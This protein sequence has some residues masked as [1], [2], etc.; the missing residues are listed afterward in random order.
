MTEPTV[1]FVE[2]EHGSTFRQEHTRK[3]VDL[4][5]NR[6]QSRAY[7]AIAPRRTLCLPWGRGVG[8]SWFIRAI[9]FMLVAQWRGKLRMRGKY[10]PLRGVRVV[11]LMPTLKQFKDVHGALIERENT[12]DWAFLGGRLDK[13]TWRI[14]F[15]DGSWIQPFPAELAN[16]RR[17]RGLR[18]DVVLTDETDD[19][20][21]S[22]FEAVARP[23]FSE[24][25]SLKIRLC[26]GTPTRGRHGLL[27][28][29]HAAGLSAAPQDERY[30]TFHATYRD[31]PETVDAEE[32]EDARAHTVPATFA[33]E[34]ECDFDAAEGLVYPFD[35][36]FHVLAPPTGTRFTEYLV[37]V[38]HGWTDAG[39]FL[40]IG[41]SGHGKDAVAWVLS[42]IY[43]TEKVSSWWDDQARKLQGATFWC[44]PSRPDR[45]K[46]L[47][48]RGMVNAR[49]A[50]NDID[51]G[52]SRVA[53]M[54]FRRP[55]EGGDDFARLYVH[56]SCVNTIREFKSYRRKKD[57][58][59]ADRFTDDIEDRNN[60][61]MDALRYAIVM[62]FG[63]LAN[64]KSIVS[65]A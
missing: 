45:I 60:H 33:R 29:L 53:D 62:R 10:A 43:E 14:S 44:D 4:V 1:S 61:A 36:D 3:R 2:H 55:R 5:L 18:A 37:G 19:I 42:E 40:H 39:V 38:D 26:G 27:Y 22:V 13:T 63:R 8:K 64:G 58:R 30:R 25:W 48:Q 31:A 51:G 17:A 23:W 65:G 56:P 15:P 12:D 49:G 11:F 52:V 47:Q 21:K 50:D 9:A 20:D 16:S 24:P 54:L 6:P 57:A 46:D 28:Q 59:E 35:E 34:W 41:V 32:V 7:S